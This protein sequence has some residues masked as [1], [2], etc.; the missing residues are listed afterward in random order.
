MRVTDKETQITAD[1]LR[2]KG[3]FIRAFEANWRAQRINFILQKKREGLTQSHIAELLGMKQANVSTILKETYKEV[4]VPDEPD[5]HCF[6]RTTETHDLA[7]RPESG[8]TI[9][10]PKELPPEEEYEDLFA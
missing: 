10:A 7:D 2:D 3:E 8:P 9:S 4:P 6:I 1:I 5:I